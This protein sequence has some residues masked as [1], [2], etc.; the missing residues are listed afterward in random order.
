MFQIAALLLLISALIVPRMAWSAHEAE[1]NYE[2]SVAHVHH[3]DHTHEVNDHAHDEHED[4]EHMDR[5]HTHHSHDDLGDAPLAHDHLAA[6]VLSVMA[7]IAD[8]IAT[9]Q[10]FFG[11]EAG[12]PERRSSGAPSGHPDTLLRPPRTA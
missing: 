6:D 1:H 8:T 4:R 2:R 7:A 3:G 11:S 12:V 9:E 5:E 10:P